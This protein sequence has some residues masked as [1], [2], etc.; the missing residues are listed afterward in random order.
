MEITQ[1]ARTVLERRYLIRD[2]SGK[3]TE[4]VE[5]LFHRVS[6]AIAASD[7]NYSASDDAVKA[8]DEEFYEMMTS[9][10]FLPNSPTLM[11]AG[12]PLGQL[13][14]CFVLPVAD[15][16]EAI[17]EAIKQAALIHKSGG[18]TGFSFSRLRSCGSTVNSTGGVA[19]GPISFMRV[20]NMA[21]EAVKQGG[22]RRGANMGILR[23][24]HPDILAFINCKADNADIT[25]FNISVGITEAFMKA[26]ENGEMYDL[27]EPS[28]GKAV[29]QLNAKDVFDKIVYA[30]WRNGEPG[31]IFLDRLNR[32]NV[33][34]AQGEIE[35]TNPCGEQPLLPYESCNLGSINL[36]KMI[37]KDEK[38]RYAIN[39]NKLSN[40]VCKAV[41]F[42]DNV[43]DANRYPLQQI[44]FTTKQTRKVGLGV[45]GWADM[46]LYLEIPYNSDEAVKLADKLMSFITT[47]GRAASAKLAKVRGAF[48][49]FH[50]SIFKDGEPLRN[51]TIT[52]IAPTGTL[53]IIAGVSSGVEP[54]FSYVYIRSVMDRTEMIEVNPVLKDLLE[55]RGLYSE[56]LMHRIAQE[57][58]IAHMDDIPADIRRV[59]VSA[60]DVSPLFHAKMQAAFQNHTDN[61][62]SKT[63]NFPHDAT[64]EEVAEVYTLAYKL[65]CKGVTIYRDGSRE[66]QV[67]NLEK[68]DTPKEA[69]TPETAVETPAAEAPVPAQPVKIIPRPRPDVT[70]GLTEKVAIGCGNLYITVNYDDEGICEVF[71][72]TGKAGGCPSQS[73]AT[74][75]LVSVAL[76]SGLDVKTITGQLRGIRCPSTIRQHGMKCTSC[77]DAIARVIEKV[78]AS[79]DFKTSGVHV[80]PSEPAKPV[81]E[82][83][84]AAAIRE[85]PE[86]G[87]KV[88]HEGGCVMCRNCGYSKCG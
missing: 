35:S 28:T 45:M 2:D 75:R 4:T 58:T 15:T 40:T 53:S 1:N 56:E 80:A 79:K 74:A 22:T 83:A 19:S 82:P 38:G 17:F 51:A 61:A 67:L 71:T 88:E 78:V 41:H 44:D 62:V 65:G 14:A 37:D 5:D 16:M 11:N 9:L 24:D 77:P 36:V 21:T 69:I 66:I 12:R 81:R 63:V 27:I 50:E 68:K 84:V 6:K 85:C 60:H 48:P 13:S 64:Q 31:I 8:V 54:V 49:L 70:Q 30:A 39:W 7:L 72:N 20:F 29:A 55:E 42:L 43:I 25:N 76:R 3:P 33:V 34:P 46:L 57:G 23:V 59:F 47:A 26:V 32:D 86:C 73:E 87:A 10:E 18:G 52:T